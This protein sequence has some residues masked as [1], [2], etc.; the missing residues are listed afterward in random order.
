MYYLLS[1]IS[2]WIIM[3]PFSCVLRMEMKKQCI[4]HCRL[5]VFVVAAK[6][7]TSKVYVAIFARLLVQFPHV[8]GVSGLSLNV[9]LDHN[10]I[11]YIQLEEAWAVNHTVG[12]SSPSLVKLIK[13]L[14]QASNPKI[15]GS[16]E[17]RPKLGG[18]VYHNNIMGALKIHLCRT[19]IRHVA[20]I[21]QVAWCCQPGRVALCI[22]PDY[23]DSS[24][25]GRC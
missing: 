9:R 7:I 14:Q 3:L 12:R 10:A 4:V 18:P 21:R 22:P 17:S 2:W 23:T 8:Q 13:S 15:D 19:D 1:Y 20:C 25:G 6:K 5:I 16:F 11:Q 24:R